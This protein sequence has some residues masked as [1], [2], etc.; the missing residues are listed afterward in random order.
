MENDYIF[1]QTSCII[2]KNNFFVSIL[3]FFDMVFILKLKG[4][5]EVN[6]VLP[7]RIYYNHFG[8]YKMIDFNIKRHELLF[9]SFINYVLIIYKIFHLISKLAV[10]L[11]G[12]KFYESFT[13]DDR[14]CFQRVE[15]KNI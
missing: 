10:T 9:T 5:V 1:V 11:L 6:G 4:G 2:I 15:C 3:F 13:R 7:N 8:D 14:E 12:K